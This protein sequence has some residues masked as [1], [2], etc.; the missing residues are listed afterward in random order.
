MARTWL[1]LAQVA[2][3]LIER[4]RRARLGPF[5]TEAF[6]YKRDLGPRLF[7]KDDMFVREATITAMQ[8][9]QLTV[10]ALDRLEAMQAGSRS[11]AGSRSHALAWIGRARDKVGF[12]HDSFEH[13]FAVAS[14]WAQFRKQTLA[15]LKHMRDHL[16]QVLLR[17]RFAAARRSASSSR[18]SPS[19]SGHRR[20]SS[21]RSRRSVSTPS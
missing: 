12:L 1:E 15:T 7:S 16:H 11:R 17:L 14:G 21:D 8:L 20:M 13:T 2:T 5:V 10:I 4:G 6:R 3:D 19:R 18:S 9:G